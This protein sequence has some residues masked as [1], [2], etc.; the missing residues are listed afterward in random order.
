MVELTSPP[1]GEFS[2]AVPAAPARAPAAPA[3]GRR[4]RRCWTSPPGCDSA[5]PWLLSAIVHMTALIVLGLLFF[6]PK[7]E[8]DL[9]LDAG[10]SDDVS[11]PLED[12]LDVA[13]SDL[14][15][16]EARRARLHRREPAA[17]R[18]PLLDARRQATL[19]RTRS[20]PTGT[21]MPTTIG[22]ALTGREAG[23][24]GSARSRPTAAPA[25]PKAPSRSGSAGSPIASSAPASGVSPVPTTTAAATTTTQPPPPWPCSRSKAP[26]TRPKAIRRT[27][28]RPSS[29]AAGI[30]CSSSRTR[31]AS[32]STRSAP[33][34]SSTRRPCA[35]SRCASCSA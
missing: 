21:V 20:L 16:L 17:S 28:S 18:R 8:D 10:Y 30:S 14:D 25:R 34:S 1:P 4:S 2:P 6:Q 26:A 23:H 15:D 7:I 32:S 27:R 19:R 9:L 11:I 35:R 12:D 33:T 31:T 3:S 5:P 13:S 22:I 29:A 24:E